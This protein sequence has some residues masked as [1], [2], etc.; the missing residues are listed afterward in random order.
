MR[1]PPWQFWL[2]LGMAL[3]LSS[4][5]LPHSLAVWNPDWVA[6]VVIYWV[7]NFPDRAGVGAA[8]FAGLLLDVM[9]GGMLG[10]N[11]LAMT[12]VGYLT[13]KMYLR[14]RVFP[15]S[16]QSL[17]VAL[18]LGLYHFILFWVQGIVGS[19]GPD[20]NRWLA[21]TLSVLAWIPLQA[22]LGL[23]WPRMSRN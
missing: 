5:P 15:L 17:A 14:I 11:A 2:T 6:L 13:L 22:T 21:I 23:L 19:V 10:A 3:V 12:A 9:Q 16:Q 20:L 1:L 18:I 8:W 7:L 4:I